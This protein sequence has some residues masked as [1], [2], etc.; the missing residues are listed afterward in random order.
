MKTL[1]GAAIGLLA[2]S[3][4]IA[5]PTVTFRTFSAH[6]ETIRLADR[7]G[8]VN[9]EAITCQQQVKSVTRDEVTGKVTFEISDFVSSSNQPGIVDL[10]GKCP[11]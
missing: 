1:I 8:S 3:A 6:G 11:L 9:G 10:Q 5:E 7:T 4:A 2:I